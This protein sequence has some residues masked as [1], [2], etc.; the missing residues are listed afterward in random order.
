LFSKILFHFFKRF[1]MKWIL[2]L[3]SLSFNLFAG[4][5]DEISPSSPDEI[6]SL[7]SDLIIEGFVSVM[8]GQISLSEID[9]HVKGSQDLLLKRTYVPPQ[10]LGRYDDKDERDRL[11]LGKALCQLNTKG[12]VVLPHLWAGYNVNSPYFQVMDP[13]G[14]VL[15]FQIQGNRGILKTSSCGCSNLRSGEP[16]SLADIRNI[17]LLVEGNQIKIIWSEGTQR[18]YISQGNRLYRLSHEFLPNGKAIRYEYNN[19][20]LIRISSTDRSGKYTYASID[21]IGNHRY[22]G[23]DGREVTLTYE[24]REI[25]GKYKKKHSKE[26][27]TYSFPVM[28]RASNPTYL[29]IAEYDDRTLLRS[30]DAKKYTVSCSYFK[31][32]DVLSRIQTFST[33]SGSTS[34]SYDPP[35]AGQK[36]GSTIVDYSNGLKVIYRFNASLLLTSRENWLQ[37]KLY[38]QKLFTYDAKQHISKVE[39]KDDKGN[40]LFTKKYEC[41]KFGNP[42]LETCIGDFGTFSIKR[43]FSKNRLI[44]EK[45]D[46]GLGFE[47][48]YLGDTHLVTSKITLMDDRPIRKALYSYDN[49]NNLIEEKEEGQTIIKYHLYQEGPYLHRIEW[50]EEIDWDG[51]LIHKVRYSYDRF[52]NIAKEEHYGADGKFAYSIDKIYDE[53]GNLVEETNPINQTATYIY[54]A[55][56]RPIKEIPF[57]QRLTIDRTFDNKGRITLLKEGDHETQFTYNAMDELIEKTDYLGLTT[58]CSYHPVHGKPVLIEAEPTSQKIIYDSFGRE[59]ERQDAYGASTK[60]KPNSLGDPMEIIHPDGGKEIFIYAANGLLLEKKDP[61]GLK[62]S[63]SYDPLGRV[64]SKKEGNLEATYH[65]DAYHLI[66]EKDPLGY[67]TTYTYNLAGQ[68]IREERARRVTEFTYDSLGFLAGK[69]R[70]GRKISFKNDFLGR[71][72]EKNIDDCLITTYTYDPA[73]KVASISKGDPIYFSYDP[74][75]RII[76]K[77]D[78]NGAKTTISYEEGDQFL[79]KKTIDPRGVQ[80]LETYNAHGLLLKR[81]SPNTIYEEFGYDKALRLI[82]Q[83][84]LTF[85][86]TLEGFLSSMTETGKRTTY[87]TY[88]PAGKVKTKQKPDGTIIE[89]EYNHHGKLIKENSREFEYDFLGRLTQ[90]TGFKR[91]LD[92]FGNIIK[93]KLSNGL[94]IESSYDDWDRPLIRTLPDQS[95]ILYSYDGPFLTT[96][97]RKDINGSILYTH[98]YDQFDSKG[99]LL[100]ETGLFTTTYTYDKSG[101][102]IYQKSPFFEEKLE[103]DLAGN[104]IRKGSSTYV[105]DDACQLISEEG[106]FSV[107][108][109]QHYNSIWKNGEE[110]EIDDLNQRNDENY[111]LNGNLL[112]DGF[113]YDEFDQLVQ[114]KDDY[115]LYDALGRRLQSNDTFYFYISDEEIGSFKNGNIKELK[116]LGYNS[117]ITIEIQR[118]PYATTTDVQNTIRQLI[119]WKLGEIAFT[120]SCDAFGNGITDK[121]PYAYIGKRYDTST[122]LLYFGKRFYDP[123]LGIWLTQDPSGPIDHSN[124]YQYVYNNPYRFQDP[125]GENVLG[126]LCGVGQILL[127]GAIMA[128]GAVLEVA[129]FG[130]YTFALGFHEAAGLSLMA[131]GCAMAV[132]NAQDIKTPNIEI[133][134]ITW[135]NTDVYAPDRPLPTNEDGVPI[136]EADAPHTELGNKESKRRPGEKYPQAR[137]FDENG[138]PVK[139]IDFTDHGEPS[140]HTNP[141]EHPY[142]P[143]PTGGTPIRGDPQ[144]LDTWRY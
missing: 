54:D 112:K 139:T 66:K 68:K 98:S 58:S 83:D 122:G 92:P 132:Y 99:N 70:A 9:L 12:W 114:T 25:K 120:N 3:I 7:N 96:V 88:T 41:D 87:W 130:G 77:I 82:S 24:N 35:I 136:P 16:S 65:Y 15:E 21:K 56:S 135:K 144:P 119:D 103:Y 45:R 47:Y 97:T 134:N 17:E 44:S 26:E 28:T 42:I 90:G 19:Q 78:A 105:Y 91:E 23:S 117:P 27:A 116:V 137:E 11:A 33:P 74:Y 69:T 126:F 62:T 2:L 125:N 4:S 86:Y 108:Y 89:H 100:E 34:F 8:S 106:C 5:F 109:D 104:L 142:K 32:K 6:A 80:K 36:G 127:G 55:R 81:E 110:I 30:Y 79:I 63:F 13:G 138:K 39:T 75:D 57:S 141:H 48:T 53:K 1:C 107:K 140:V 59:I 72:L 46:D 102:R 20:G 84:H 131:S 10:I 121:I 111:V 18:I 71:T 76:E 31:Q 101:K 61:D 49:A 51:N 93:E 128:S 50:K 123:S 64:L 94:V 37:G 115:Y 60:T 22:R 67:V 14:Y 118:K 52:G 73:G 129:T 95:Q 143:N 85:T 133:P 40:I 38:N 43:S 124:L 29:N 113:V